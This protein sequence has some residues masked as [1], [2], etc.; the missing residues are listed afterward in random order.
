MNDSR[1]PMPTHATPTHASTARTT[2]THASTAV[3]RAPTAARRTR[4][5]ASLV[6]ALLAMA[7]LAACKSNGTDGSTTTGTSRSDAVRVAASATAAP[8]ATATHEATDAAPSKP[9][10]LCRTKPDG[11]GR[12][13]PD[14]KL[15]HLEATGET[16]EPDRIATVSGRWTWVNFWAGW[17][18]PCREEMPRLRAF[19]SRS[20]NVHVAF[21]SLDDDERQAK[22]FLDTQPATG[23]R[24]SHWL[25][26]DKA[27]EAFF[28]ALRVESIPTLPM[29]LLFGPDGKLRCRIDGAV[30]DVDLP[31][32][33]KVFAEK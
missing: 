30:E 8:T 16:A 2:A 26:D 1:F 19:E 14:V 32:L 17:C 10:V 9:R 23:L 21:V 31:S 22:Q 3:S 20:T 18:G 13:L 7:S 4:I 5:A 33:E 11:A 12:P 27:R 29:H 15:G 24:R 25:A 28:T 6:T